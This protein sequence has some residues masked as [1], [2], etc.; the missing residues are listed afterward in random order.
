MTERNIYVEQVANGS[1]RVSKN[2]ERFCRFF[3]TREQPTEELAR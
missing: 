2:R 3:R 1:W